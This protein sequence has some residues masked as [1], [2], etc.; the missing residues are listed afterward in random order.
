MHTIFTHC[1]ACSVNTHM[2]FAHHLR[3]NPILHIRSWPANVSLVL[4]TS[5]VCVGGRKNAEQWDERQS[6][7][8]LYT[9][10][11]WDFCAL[12]GQRERGEDARTYPCWTA[13][14]AFVQPGAGAAAVHQPLQNSQWPLRGGV[15]NTVSIKPNRPSLKCHRFIISAVFASG[16]QCWK[17]SE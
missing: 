2:C 9:M 11:N 10:H 14:K 4:K 5:S 12:F 1:S 8:F 3:L 17:R 16:F 6:A 13:R 7:I 15:T